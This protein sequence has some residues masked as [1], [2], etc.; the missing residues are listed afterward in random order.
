MDNSLEQLKKE[1]PRL[2]QYEEEGKIVFASLLETGR[3]WQD[4]YKSEGNV[5]V[6]AVPRFQ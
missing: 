2:R 6:P 1:L 3:I 5:Y 4:R